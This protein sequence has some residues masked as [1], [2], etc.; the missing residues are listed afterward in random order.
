MDILSKIVMLNEVFNFVPQLN[1]FFD[2]M[3]MILMEATILALVMEADEDFI[4]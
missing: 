2:I 4:R 3:A 1:A